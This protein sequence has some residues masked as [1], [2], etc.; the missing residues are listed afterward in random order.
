[1]EV[2]NYMELTSVLQSK[3]RMRAV[4]ITDIA[5]SKVSVVKFRG[6]TEQENNLIREYHKLLLQLAQKLCDKH[7]NSEYEYGILINIHT[8]NH[9]EIEGVPNGVYM[10]SSPAAKLAL[11]NGSKNSLFY[12]HNHPS[13]GTFSAADLKTFLLNE[14]IFI[15]TAVGND[16]FVYSVQKTADVD[17][18]GFLTDYL[19]MA[20]QYRD[21]G[22]LNNA[23][24]ALK[25]IMKKSEK[26]GVIYM[27]GGR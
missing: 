2:N 8:W 6:F 12:M 20:E 16:G 19:Q 26:Y 1:M 5:I 21:D 25:D 18:R 13:T 22:Y 15:M 27:K 14:A 24:L 4:A 7:K 17:V 3:S 9:I 10:D 11:E 23:T